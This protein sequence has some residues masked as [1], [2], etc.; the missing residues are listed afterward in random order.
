MSKLQPA[1]GQ[2][3]FLERAALSDLLEILLQDGYSV[4][5]PTVDQDVIALRPIKSADELARGMRDDHGRGEYR[6]AQGE[7]DLYFEYV[8][9]ADSPKRFVFPPSLQLFRMHQD[10]GNFAFDAGPPKPPR[11]ALFAIRPCDLAALRIMDRV[12]SSPSRCESDHYYTK[13][14]QEMFVVVA[15]CT[16]PGDNCFCASTDSGPQATEGFDLALTELRSGFLMKVGSARGVQMAGKLEVRDPSP[17]ELELG[18]LRIEQAREHMGKS[19]DIDGV[20]KVLSDGLEHARWNDVAKRCLSCGNCTSVCPTCT[21][22]SVADSSDVGTSQVARMRLWDSCH[23][24]Q[25][26]YTTSG[27]LRASVRARYRHWLRHKLFTYREQYGVPGCVGCGRCI[28][29]CPVGIDITEEAAALQDRNTAPA[30]AKSEV[31][32]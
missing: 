19:I 2:F 7:T 17:A 30:A 21:C 8:V 9:G 20:S 24:L 31:T 11:L 1:V 5:G 22:S 6:L 3:V 23:T 29:W 28:T 26:T 14:R 15:N 25:F 13:A 16:R 10:N 32:A 27:P 12:F 4:I 18:E